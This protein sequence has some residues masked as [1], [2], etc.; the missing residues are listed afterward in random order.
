MKTSSEKMPEPEL[1]SLSPDG[2]SFYT[3]VNRLRIE[4]DDTV[5]VVAYHVIQALNAGYILSEHIELGTTLVAPDRKNLY[6]VPPEVM[7]FLVREGLVHPVGG[8][9][10]IQ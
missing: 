7:L 10:T 8:T 2:T 6:I 1:G 4:G 9:G 3:Q 5:D